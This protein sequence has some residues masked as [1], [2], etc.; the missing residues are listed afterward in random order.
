MFLLL[1]PPIGFVLIY[2][3]RLGE[4][5]FW[6]GLAFVATLGFAIGNAGRAGNVGLFEEALLGEVF[7][8]SLAGIAITN[9]SPTSG[10]RYWAGMSLMMAIS[11]LVIGAVRMAEERNGRAKFFLAQIVHWAATLLVLF[12]VHELYRA[13]RLNHDNA[14]LVL[15]LILGLSTFLDGYRISWRFA[16][17]GVLLAATALLAAYV[18]KY[19]WPMVVIGFVVLLGV[20][21]FEYLRRG[22]RQGNP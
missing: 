21:A 12:A 2:F 11:A 22:R 8:L 14:A 1:M 17:T 7:I 4:V 9:I 16:L 10:L 6:I 19:T 5:Q 15:L 3:S 20:V 13:G 18:E